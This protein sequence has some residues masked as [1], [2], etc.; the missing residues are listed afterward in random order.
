[1]DKIG[2]TETFCLSF[3]SIVSA[4]V[5]AY[6]PVGKYEFLL[7]PLI[8]VLYLTILFGSSHLYFCWKDRRQVVKGNV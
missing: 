3:F 5:L 6:Y 7:F 2:I 8:A 1:M 4:S